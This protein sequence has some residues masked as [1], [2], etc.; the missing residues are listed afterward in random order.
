MRTSSSGSHGFFPAQTP[1]TQGVLGTQQTANPHPHHSALPHHDHLISGNLRTCQ[2]PLYTKI[3]R[4]T[5]QANTKDGA[6]TFAIIF[7]TE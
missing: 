3:Y 4:G 6:A 5:V 7:R 1:F 2:H